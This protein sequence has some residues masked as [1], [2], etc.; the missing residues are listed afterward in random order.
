[1]KRNLVWSVT[2]ITLSIGIEL[3]VNRFF[4]FNVCPKTGIEFFSILLGIIIGIIG[5]LLLFKKD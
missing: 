3:L 2:L 5:I 4:G 1:M